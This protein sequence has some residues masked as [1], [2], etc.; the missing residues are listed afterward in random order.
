MDFEIYAQKVQQAHEKYVAALSFQEVI[1]IV[2]SVDWNELPA[3]QAPQRPQNRKHV[4]TIENYLLQNPETYNLPTITLAAEAASFRPLGNYPFGRLTIPSSAK[5]YAID[6]QHRVH[7]LRALGKSKEFTLY[8]GHSLSIEIF[9]NL[10]LTQ[11]QDLFVTMNT[12]KRVSKTVLTAI[13]Q[14]D[15]LRIARD[16]ANNSPGFQGQ[17]EKNRTVVPK[18]TTQLFTLTQLYDTYMVTA[19]SM[20]VNKKINSVIESLILKTAS[21]IST[22]IPAYQLVRDG[23]VCERQKSLAC[24]PFFLQAIFNSVFH[25]LK[26]HALPD[27]K[28]KQRLGEIDWCRYHGTRINPIWE[29]FLLPLPQAQVI[30]RN[31][32]RDEISRIITQ[33]ILE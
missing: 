29:S 13:G 3:E 15:E 26:D 7:A 12:T 18:N 5:I 11:R 32:H 33:K 23:D 28:I 2:Q 25:I 20:L 16:M 6:G 4:H 17:I 10:S 14:S 31:S 30:R 22:A 9:V 21:L 19:K 8:E 27:T 24:D 1:Q